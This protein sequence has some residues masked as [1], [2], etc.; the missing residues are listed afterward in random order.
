[1]HIDSLRESECLLAEVL[2]GSANAN[3]G[4]ENLS[5]HWT[6]S[7]QNRFANL[8]A[9]TWRS[10]LSLGMANRPSPSLGLARL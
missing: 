7:P 4:F 2:E 10:I 8:K 5:H 1:M 6:L 9:G 3:G